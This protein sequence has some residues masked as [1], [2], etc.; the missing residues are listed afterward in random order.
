MTILISCFSIFVMIFCLTDR[1]LTNL[2]QE[3]W[4]EILILLL[5]FFTS[6]GVSGLIVLVVKTIVSKPRPSMFY[7]CNYQGF[8]SAVDSGN[9]TSYNILTNRQ[10]LGNTANCWDQDFYP[11][12]IYAF[13]SGHSTL[14]FVAF[15]WLVL[16]FIH[17]AK[18]YPFMGSLK[19]LLW[20]P[21]ILA[22]WIAYTRIYDYRHDEVD[23]LTGALIG[24]ACAAYFFQ[25]FL[26][27]FEETKTENPR[28]SEG[29]SLTSAAVA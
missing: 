3:K 14:A 13:P 2:S 26:I 19:W 22:T 8:R 18:R 5:C 15:F 10:S 6:Y 17:F 7:L 23:V 11:D 21:M 9:F 24:I 12:C 29:I 16:F 25:D 1:Q 28:K 27:F 20:F 4:K